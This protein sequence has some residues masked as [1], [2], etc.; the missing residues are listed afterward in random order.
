[1]LLNKDSSAPPKP[2]DMYKLFDGIQI[3]AIAVEDGWAMKRLCNV[4][5]RVKS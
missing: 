5:Q 1:M 2:N 4:V 3:H